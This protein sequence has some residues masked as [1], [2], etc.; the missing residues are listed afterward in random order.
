MSMGKGIWYEG[1]GLMSGSSLDGLDIAWCRFR[2][3]P[4]SPSLVLEWEL[5][6]AGTLAMPME[7]KKR[8]REL[9]EGSARDLAIAHAELGSLWGEQCR[10]FMKRHACR[11]GFI[12]SHGHTVFHWPHLGVS[13]QI[14]SGAALAARTGIPVVCDFRTSDVALGGQGAPFAP[15]AD[16]F[17][18][19]GYDYYLNIGGI[20]NI[21]FQKEGKWTAFDVGPANQIFNELAGEAGM[22]YDRGG[23]IASRGRVNE[24]LFDAV[25]RL[26]YFSQAPPKSLDNGWITREVK[27][28]YADVKIPLEDRMRT[29]VEQLA[30]QT[31]RAISQWAPERQSPSRLFASGGGAYNG[32]LIARL[33]WH[34]SR[35]GAAEVFLPEKEII[36]YKEALL[37]AL[38]G[39]FR[40][41]GITNCMA[42]V[43]GA[44][45]DSVGGTVY[46]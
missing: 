21:S 18:F 8:L 19:P 3:D 20:A 1:L 38:M 42:D 34:I 11:V 39:A 5:K 31:A 46:L 35:S 6:A 15:L 33:N 13:A 36:E 40:L 12:A 32:F 14:G 45:R 25:N 27:P 10:D 17:L 2:I 26:P 44:A 29:A 9:P 22:E 23:Q 43:T 24:A 4:E 37:I 7:W 30:W 16:R 41:A 28:L